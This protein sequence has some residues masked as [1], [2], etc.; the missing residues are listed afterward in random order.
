MA[1]KTYELIR[2]TIGVDKIEKIGEL[3]L[4]EE[5]SKLET[6][7]KPIAGIRV[8]GDIGRR[9]SRR[10]SDFYVSLR[11]E[12]EKI[13][14]EMREKRKVTKDVIERIKTVQHKLDKR[15]A[16]RRRLKEIFPVFDVLRDYFS[17]LARVKEVSSEIIQ[18]LKGRDLLSR[19]SFLKRRQ[20]KEIRRII[21]EGIIRNFGLVKKIDEIE[22]R[23]FTNLEEE[24]E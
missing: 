18:E 11:E 5:L 17:D 1:R 3:E 10:R 23:T 16:E 24:Y 7:R 15:E 6:E 14:E 8:L 2:E 9:V 22:R 12:I 20:R 21:R 19:E 4:A 13:Y